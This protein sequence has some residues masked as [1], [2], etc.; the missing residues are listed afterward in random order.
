MGVAGRLELLQ[1][2]FTRMIF[3][4]YLVT[5]DSTNEC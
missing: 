5:S 1:P 4:I 3:V 2:A